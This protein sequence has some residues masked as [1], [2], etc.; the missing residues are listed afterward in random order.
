MIQSVEFERQL[1][2]V[3]G[4]VSV[5]GWQHRVSQTSLARKSH[6]YLSLQQNYVQNFGSWFLRQYIYHFYWCFR[7]IC[8]F[9]QLI[10]IRLLWSKRGWRKFGQITQTKKNGQITQYQ[11]K[12]EVPKNVKRKEWGQIRPWVKWIKRS[13]ETRVARQTN[14]LLW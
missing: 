8:Q 3:V 2:S 13:R 10:K 5:N 6:S 12:E 4:R 7:W 1:E 9:K 11:I 14:P